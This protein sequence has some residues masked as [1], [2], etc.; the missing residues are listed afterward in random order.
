[1]L[2]VWSPNGVPHFYPY[3]GK[4]RKFA[5]INAVSYTL[6]LLSLQPT[7]ASSLY[8]G[9]AVTDNS[10]VAEPPLR[11]VKKFATR[12]VKLPTM[13][14]TG[15]CVCMSHVYVHPQL[16]CPLSQW[17]SVVIIFR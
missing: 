12:K 10:R 11:R 7:E 16:S 15:H 1:M 17:L 13:C 9:N 4:G 6:V 2:F 14:D 3:P 5:A 8:L